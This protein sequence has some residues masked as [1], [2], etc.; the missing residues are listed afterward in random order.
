MVSATSNR[1][2]RYRSSSFRNFVG[3]FSPNASHSPEPEVG[4]APL[5]LL[6][7]CKSWTAIALSTPALWTSI[8]IYFPCSKSFRT[9]VLPAWL[10][11]AHNRPL[12]VSFLGEFRQWNYRVSAMVWQHAGQLKHW[13]CPARSSRTTA[14]IYSWLTFLV[15]RV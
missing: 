3:D 11:R 14:T 15:R 8:R 2:N 5:L 4:L 9:W 12:S 6:R 1:F 13:K 10:N 7:V